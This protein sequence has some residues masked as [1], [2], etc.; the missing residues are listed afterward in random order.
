MTDPTQHLWWLASRSSGIVAMLLLTFTVV[1]GLMMGGKLV[2][3]LTGKQGRGALA[4]KSLLQ[5]H[6]QA[7]IAALIA[8]GVHGVTLLGDDG[9]IGREVERHFHRQHVVRV[10]AWIHGREALHGAHEQA[11]AREQHNAHRDLHDDERLL[12]TT[13]AHATRCFRGAGLQALRQRVFVADG[14]HIRK[15]QRDDE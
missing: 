4:I 5:T 9:I 14:R 12:Q 2:N 13:T 8:V 15:N 7:S 1:V 3:K 6:E 11:R 10:E